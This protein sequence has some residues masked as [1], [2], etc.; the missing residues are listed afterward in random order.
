M[1]FARNCRVEERGVSVVCK[2]RC[3]RKGMEGLGFC[4]RNGLCGV[5]RV[6]GVGYL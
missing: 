3:L 1:L 4:A 5:G 2:T 6:S